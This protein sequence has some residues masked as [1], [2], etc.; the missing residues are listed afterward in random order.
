MSTLL[1]LPWAAGL[2]LPCLPCP[3]RD[4]LGLRNRRLSLPS[5]RRRVQGADE[6]GSN[7]GTSR[8]ALEPSQYRV[9]ASTGHNMPTFCLLE[10]PHAKAGTGGF[11]SR[12]LD[13]MGINVHLNMSQRSTTMRYGVLLPHIWPPACWR[14]YR[15][16]IRIG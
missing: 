12:P 13:A 15:N 11:R 5:V 8:S 6:L 3:I 16:R 9:R 14:R 1:L 10:L 7:V 4:R 2:V